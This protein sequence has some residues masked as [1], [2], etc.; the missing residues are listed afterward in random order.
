MRAAVIGGLFVG[1]VTVAC[2][3][4]HER[5]WL[6]APRVSPASPLA[7]G[8]A[9]SRAQRRPCGQRPTASTPLPD[10]AP[11][12]TSSVSTPNDPDA[13]ACP[14]LQVVLGP[15]IQ[16][17]GQG[18]TRNGAPGTGNGAEPGFVGGTANDRWPGCSRPRPFANGA[19]GRTDLWVSCSQRAQVRVASVD[20]KL[21]N[22]D[23]GAI[24][25][26]Q[27]IGVEECG[28]V[29][30]HSSVCNV[31][32]ADGEHFWVY[33]LAERRGLEDPA[34][35]YHGTIVVEIVGQ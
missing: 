29:T 17:W 15:P 6:P 25:A 10:P 12:P 19:V 22:G 2:A 34:G 26:T 33:V 8:A 31:G 3:E 4:P 20:L 27:W 5:V 16:T 32:P 14:A 11:T 24:N 28:K 35:T 21:T 23:G 30:L 13:P 7:R 9:P 18:H 1:I